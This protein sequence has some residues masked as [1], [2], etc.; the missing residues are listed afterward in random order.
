MQTHVKS[1]PYSELICV[2]VPYT[3]LSSIVIVT[4]YQHYVH[5][6]TSLNKITSL[7]VGLP[8]GFDNLFAVNVLD[9]NMLI[10]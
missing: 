7:K 8:N 10:G 4:L 3:I 2:V 5:A 1:K 9:I 6:N